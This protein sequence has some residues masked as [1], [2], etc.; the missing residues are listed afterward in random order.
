L[1]NAGITP[2]KILTIGT[3]AIPE[4]LI[5]IRKGRLDATIQYPIYQAEIALET[6]VNYLKTGTLPNWKD[7]LVKP[8]LITRENISTGDFYHIIQN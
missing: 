5:A 1:E 3:D 4:A 6:L 2:E 7:Y 8:W